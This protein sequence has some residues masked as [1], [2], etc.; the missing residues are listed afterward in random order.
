MSEKQPNFFAIGSVIKARWKITSKIGQGAF[1][2]TYTAFDLNTHENVA[3]KV[4][5]VQAKKQVLKLE[6]A[7]LKKLQDSPYFC[8][9]IS[10]GHVKSREPDPQNPENTKA[11]NYVVMQ[12]LGQNLSDLRK[13]KPDNKFSLSTTALLIKQMLTA[14]ETMHDKGYIHR[15]VKP[16]NFAVGLERAKNEGGVVRP[17]CYMF[18]FGL[19]RR[20]LT[21]NNKVREPRVVA[22]FRGTA[23]YASLNAHKCREL[24]RRDDLWSVFYL[25]VEFLSGQ[26]PWRKEKDKDVVGEIK[27]RYT[28]ETLVASLPKPCQEFYKYLLTLNYSDRPNYKYLHSIVDDLFVLSG[29]PNDV[30]YD[31]ERLENEDVTES[32]VSMGLQTSATAAKA[33]TSM[34]KES[35]DDGN[36]AMR[37]SN[38]EKQDHIK[39]IESDVNNVSIKVM[40]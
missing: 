10:C 40:E 4:E 5:S 12:L 14:L 36:E 32:G 20:Y 2:Q 8:R 24:G 30:A 19:S 26:L 1:G 31:W 18:D 16:S 25:M 29:D 23:R 27:E 38:D 7:I 9:F 21:A 39:K 13:S 3:I 37:V 15:D 17:L 11:Y 28:N 34:K 33:V 35:E 6:V 22:G